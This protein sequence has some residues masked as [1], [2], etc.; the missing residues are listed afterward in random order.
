MHKQI[1]GRE[2]NLEFLADETSHLH[3]SG[4]DNIPK[5]PSAGSITAKVRTGEK[6]NTTLYLLTNILDLN[7]GQIADIYLSS[8]GT[9]RSSFAFCKKSA[10]EAPLFQRKRHQSGLFPPIID[11]NHAPAFPSCGVNKRDG[12]KP[13]NLPSRMNC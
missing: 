9:S 13:Q 6:A 12:T 5:S 3:K 10:C 11:R 8:A 7:A 2:Q 4:G 1:K